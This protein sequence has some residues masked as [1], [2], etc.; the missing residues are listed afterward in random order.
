MYDFFFVIMSC[1]KDKFDEIIALFD[2]SVNIQDDGYYNS[3]C[4]TP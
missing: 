2:S 4:T 1:S 3:S